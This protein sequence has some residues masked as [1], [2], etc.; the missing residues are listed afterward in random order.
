MLSALQLEAFAAVAASGHFSEAAARVGL[1]QSALSQRIL[2]LESELETTLF[3]REPA[4]ARLT[5]AGEKLLRYCRAREALETEAVAGLKSARP[6]EL[7]GRVRIAGFSTFNRSRLLPK[8]G[9]F[10]RRHPGVQIEVLTREV[11]ELPALLRSGRADFV[12]TTN[13]LERS[14]VESLPLGF[15]ENVLVTSTRKEAPNDVFIDHDE[16]DTTTVEFWKRQGKAGGPRNY[17]RAYFDEIYTILDAVE[18]GFGRAVVPAHLLEGRPKL[19]VV[20]GLKPLRVPIFVAS[21]RQAFYTSLQK[22]LRELWP[23]LLR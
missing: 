19:R 15:E 23:Q 7:A 18:E 21:F 22:A 14:E 17:R 3:L 2:N 10:A 4:G 5:E 13:P 16:D 8:L 20:P 6:G 11:R 12:F 1:T 9:D